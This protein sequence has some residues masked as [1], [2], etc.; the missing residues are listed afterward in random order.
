MRD[1]VLDTLEVEARAEGKL[2]EKEIAELRLK[3]SGLEG[4]LADCNSIRVS[5]WSIGQ[6]L[7][8]LKPTPPVE[9][10]P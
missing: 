2:L 8:R 6:A 10:V 3:L 7:G 5:V 4:R 1:E 9:P